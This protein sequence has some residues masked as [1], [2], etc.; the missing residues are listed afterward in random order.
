MKKLCVIVFV[1]RRSICVNPEESATRDA[2]HR[3]NLEGIKSLRMGRVFLLSVEA[4]DDAEAKIMAE[5]ACKKLL[6]N[7]VMEQF[8][9]IKIEP[10]E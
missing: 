6:V 7:L 5:T 4:Q 2:L 10:E 3:L 8:E 9:I 1:F